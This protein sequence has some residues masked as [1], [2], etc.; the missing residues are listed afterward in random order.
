MNES[1]N[2]SPSATR[3][4]FELEEETQIRS[5]DC[6]QLLESLSESQLSPEEALRADRRQT[7]APKI[8]ERRLIQSIQSESRKENPAPWWK[9]WLRR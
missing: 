3:L 7:V 8:I 2:H 9:K 6:Q 5:T 4:Q 1:D